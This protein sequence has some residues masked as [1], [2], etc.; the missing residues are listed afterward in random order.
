MIRK[1]LDWLWHN[2]NYRVMNDDPDMW[3]FNLIDDQ[4]AIPGVPATFGALP[5]VQMVPPPA[6]M[7]GE[8]SSM[9]KAAAKDL[10][11]GEKGKLT[12]IAT[13]KGINLAI[14][15]KVNDHVVIT[16]FIAKNWGRPL[17]AGLMGTVSW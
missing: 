2:W 9:V 13:T 1:F 10:A 4:P 14:V 11:E 15:N 7:L 17:E 16:G 6:L 5:S 8:V 12:W 3:G